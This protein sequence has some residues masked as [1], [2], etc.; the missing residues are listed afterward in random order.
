MTCM[1]E[2]YVAGVWSLASNAVLHPRF[3]ALSAYTVARGPLLVSRGFQST[4]SLY[5]VTEHLT[6]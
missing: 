6:L 5:Y 4:S 1:I 2:I 3:S